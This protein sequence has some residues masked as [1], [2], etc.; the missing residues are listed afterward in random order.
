MKNHQFVSYIYY[1]NKI[2]SPFSFKSDT[3][4]E[5][6]VNDVSKHINEVSQIS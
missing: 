3:I 5:Y 1:E 2:I 4:K 6:E